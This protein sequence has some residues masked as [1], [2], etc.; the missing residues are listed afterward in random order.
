MRYGEDRC[1][2][3]LILLSARTIALINEPLYHYLQNPNSITTTQISP[4]TMDAILDLLEFKHSMLSTH[5]LLPK[6]NLTWQLYYWDTIC[7]YHRV[8]SKVPSPSNVPRC[9]SNLWRATA[10]FVP[11][12]IW[13]T[14]SAACPLR[15]AILATNYVLKSQH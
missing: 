15:G 5:A 3:E 4:R 2:N 6:L 14:N 1:W 10:P 8:C 13:L 11:N 9:I 7:Y 12:A